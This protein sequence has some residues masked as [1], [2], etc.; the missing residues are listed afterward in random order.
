MNLAQNN[1]VNT[2]E[3]GTVNISHH[4][5][6]KTVY[7]VLLAA[8]LPVDQAQTVS[9]CLLEAELCGVVSHGV[10][11]LGSH[12][13]KIKSGGYNIHPHL[14]VE[15]ESPSFAVADAD[16]AIGFVSA[17]HC[18]EYAIQKSREN[19]IFTVASH[20]GNTYGAAFYYA[21]MAARQGLI[22]ITFC[23]GPAAMPVWGG[24]DRL[25]GTNPFAIAVP[26]GGEKYI[27]FD[28]ATSK[29]AKSKINQ[30]RIN[31]EEIPSGWALDENGEPTT[32]P[33]RA[34]NGLILPMEGY[35]GS[36][37]A[38][39]IDILAGVLSGASFLN[40]VGKFYSRD[41]AC[42]NVG[43]TFISIDPAQIYGDNFTGAMEDYIAAIKSSA[44]TEG[45]SIRIPGENRLRIRQEQLEHGINLDKSVLD[46]IK[47][48]L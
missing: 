39:T 27:I 4:A 24:R 44:A 46:N 2:A 11:T 31:Q 3:S 32:D 37:L 12:I 36:G 34:I 41:D 42:M 10:S 26:C 45:Q 13:K 6:A 40:N 21:L 38:M 15:R 23:N 29:A 9:D 19:G 22:G 28:M 30:A 1:E 48:L 16:N 25:L 47:G 17:A 5:L 18:M 43:Q 7:E 14:R 8:A 20:G 33:I 35:K